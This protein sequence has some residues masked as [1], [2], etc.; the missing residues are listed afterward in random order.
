M[1]GSDLIFFNSVGAIRIWSEVPYRNRDGS[2]SYK[3]A[4]FFAPS[5]SLLTRLLIISSSAQH[6]L[7]RYSFQHLS[8]SFQ[9]SWQH[10]HPLLPR[11]LRLKTL[12]TCRETHRVRVREIPL[13][14]WL[15]VK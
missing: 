6:T 11:P 3:K 5:L 8:H 4:S 7:L 10:L 14:R 15:P 2:L 1:G 13:L 12:L 9:T